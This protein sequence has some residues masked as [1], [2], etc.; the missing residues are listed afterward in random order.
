M[1]RDRPRAPKEQRKSFYYRLLTLNSH[2]AQGLHYTRGTLHVVPTEDSMLATLGLIAALGFGTKPLPIDHLRL[3]R[4][5][6]LT[7]RARVSVWMNKAD[8]YARGDRARV[9][10]STEQDA[11]LT[12]LRIDTDGR[13]RVLFPHDPWDDNWVPGGRTFEVEDRDGGRNDV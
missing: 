2:L 5:L 9:Y 3:Y 8:P 7:E 6:N 13:V 12:V 10:V 1:D 11:F 4:A